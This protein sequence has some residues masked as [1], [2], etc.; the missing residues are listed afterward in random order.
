MPYVV[1]I[2]L[3]VRGCL[4]GGSMI[5][6]NYYLTPQWHRLLDSEVSINKH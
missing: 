5:G 4:L 3:L 1:L 6:I 2:I